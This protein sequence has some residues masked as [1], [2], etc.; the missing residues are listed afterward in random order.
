[1]KKSFYLL[2]EEP[3]PE[4]HGDDIDIALCCCDRH[5]ELMEE[6]AIA[7]SGIMDSLCWEL[8]QGVQQPEDICRV[9]PLLPHRG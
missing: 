3:A 4:I 6:E 7:M 1:M 5:K 9:P 8:E 2:L